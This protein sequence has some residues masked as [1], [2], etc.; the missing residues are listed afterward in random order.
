[1]QSEESA[2]SSKK[3][4][5]Y[6]YLLHNIV[7]SNNFHKLLSDEYIFNQTCSL[8][9]KTRIPY[10]AI[11]IIAKF[12][13]KP[14]LF[15]TPFSTS[16]S[17]LIAQAGVIFCPVVNGIIENKFKY[18]LQYIFLKTRRKPRT[19]QRATSAML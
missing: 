8:I 15:V 19:N 16:L 12:D 14:E 11:T 2:D 4:L 7:V 9:R 6:R 17:L 3:E 1:M 10:T 18:Y 5:Q 13:I